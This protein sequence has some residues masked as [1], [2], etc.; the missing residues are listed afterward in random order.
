VIRGAVGEREMEFATS[1]P[2][3]SEG[4]SGKTGR[5]KGGKQKKDPWKALLWSLK[6]KASAA[7]GVWRVGLGGFS[8]LPKGES[9]AHITRGGR[10]KSWQGK[11][12]GGEGL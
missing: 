11:P 10:Q 1:P 5:R 4:R 8:E 2:I 12:K 3:I 7:R 6:R 9:A